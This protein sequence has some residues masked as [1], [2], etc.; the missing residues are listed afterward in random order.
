MKTFTPPL[1]IAAIWLL[2]LF[3]LF[4]C[5]DS[6]TEPVAP[7][8]VDTVTVTDTV[9]VPDLKPVMILGTTAPYGWTEFR[10]D[11]L[12]LTKPPDSEFYIRIRVHTDPEVETVGM[13]IGPLGSPDPPKYRC[14]IGQVLRNCA[15]FSYYVNFFRTINVKVS[16]VLRDGTIAEDW[17]TVVIRPRPV[18]TGP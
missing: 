17:L 4:S 18:S 9:I 2:A 13:T 1:A 10:S 11:T 7:P 3:G 12:F 5:G 6:P 14:R 15:S 8:R 16:G